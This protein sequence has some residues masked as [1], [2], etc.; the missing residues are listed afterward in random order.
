MR[1]D[2]S[3]WISGNAQRIVEAD[4]RSLERCCSWFV[5]FGCCFKLALLWCLDFGLRQSRSRCATVGGV[6]LI[7]ILRLVNLASCGV[8]LQSR[9]WLGFRLIFSAGSR[10]VQFSSWGGVEI[11]GTS[12]ACRIWCISKSARKASPPAPARKPTERLR[13]L[14]LV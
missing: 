1:V 2:V 7:A 6:P 10:P 5:V 4:L 8:L 12:S 11:Q 14:P 13:Q 9:G 3:A